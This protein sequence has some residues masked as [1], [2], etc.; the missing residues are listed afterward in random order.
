M[1]FTLRATTPPDIPTL[2]RLMRDFATYEKLEA[3]FKITEAELHDALFAPNPPLDSILVDAGNATV[4][5]ALWY[6]VFG[7]FSGRYGL[8]VEDIY[9]DE[10]HRGRGIG[11][12]LFRHMARVAVQRQCLVMTWNVLDWNTPAIE[13][14]RHI[15][16]KP[17]RGWIARELSGDA[18]IALA[19]GAGN[20]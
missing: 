6:F 14:Y 17:V 16:A 1:T 12:A 11:L 19:E 10:P 7:T 13:F 5:F 20:G 15:G 18:L 3:R 9:I 2:H 8:F 4:G